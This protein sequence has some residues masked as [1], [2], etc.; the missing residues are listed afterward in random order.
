MDEV[1]ERLLKKLHADGS[2]E[3]WSCKYCEIERRMKGEATVTV[4]VPPAY[5]RDA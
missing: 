4:T 5:W 3:R 2:C 1:K